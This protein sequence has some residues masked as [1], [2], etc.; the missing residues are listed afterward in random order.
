MLTLK[1]RRGGGGGGG[2]GGL[3]ERG[4]HT[5]NKGPGKA[6]L[7]VLLWLL[8]SGCLFKHSPVDLG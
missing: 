3:G 6:N 4:N 7:I 8:Y 5:L 1:F 2:G